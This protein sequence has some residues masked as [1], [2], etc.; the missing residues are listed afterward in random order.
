ML[1]SSD[2]IAMVAVKD[3]VEAKK[4]YGEIL[5]LY[6]T[7]ENPGGV[8]YSSGTGRLFVYPAPTAGTNQGTSATWEVTGIES[9][10]NDL[11]G[12]GVDSWQ[13]F[14][15]PGA[16]LLGDVHDWGGMK[17]AWF[18]DPSGNTLGLSEIPKA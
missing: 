1:N 6:Q 8:T 10:V 9:V 5:G 7:D 13:H 12:K 2:V 11:K 18:K 15:M 16:A 14:E 3:L 4:F 17:A